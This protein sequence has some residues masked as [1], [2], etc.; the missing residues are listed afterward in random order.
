MIIEEIKLLTLDRK[1]KLSV[2]FLKINSYVL[3][4]FKRKSKNKT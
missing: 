3:L 4:G 2:K 1:G